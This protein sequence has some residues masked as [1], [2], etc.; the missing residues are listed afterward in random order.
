M[1]TLYSSHA[2]DVIG[3]AHGPYILVSDLGPDIPALDEAHF[4]DLLDDAHLHKAL[5]DAGTGVGSPDFK[6]FLHRAAAA[7]PE[8]RKLNEEAAPGEWWPAEEGCHAM[9]GGYLMSLVRGRVNWM[10]VCAL[11]NLLVPEAPSAASAVIENKEMK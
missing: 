10:L 6:A 2:C 4:R 8:I 5:Q 1:L 7:W 11:R 3:D 9:K